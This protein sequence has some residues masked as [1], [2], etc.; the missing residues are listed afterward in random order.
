MGTQNDRII[1]Q[2]RQQ[3]KE[4]RW[5]AREKKKKIIICKYMNLYY[6]RYQY[7]RWNINVIV[8]DIKRK[9][10]TVQHV[11][12]WPVTVS[13]LCVCVCVCVPISVNLFHINDENSIMRVR[14]REREGKT[15][16]YEFFIEKKKL[17]R[18][19]QC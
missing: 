10:V 7:K 1:E 15:N 8:N 12:L 5:T 3:K 2:V 16:S 4:I 9:W 17:M 19:W 13:V 11:L 18:Q 14:E 6:T